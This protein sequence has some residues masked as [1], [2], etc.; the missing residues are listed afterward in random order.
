MATAHQ[1]RHHLLR[2]SKRQILEDLEA[3]APN[4]RG[5]LVRK[6][7]KLAEADT[8]LQATLLHKLHGRLARVLVVRGDEEHVGVAHL[9]DDVRHIAVVAIVCALDG[10]P[11]G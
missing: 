11:H 6:A 1:I 5:D 4:L 8:L 10:V 3:T 7:L 9:L 2:R